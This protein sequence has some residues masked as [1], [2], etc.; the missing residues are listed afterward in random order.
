M[1]HP[2]G[3][4]DPPIDPAELELESGWQRAV[5]MA[6]TYAVSA[7]LH[8]VVAVVVLI[9]L[10]LTRRPIAHE[11]FVA[12]IIVADMSNGDDAPLQERAGDGPKED[13][14]EI[15]E[16]PPPGPQEAMEDPPKAEEPLA[17]PPADPTEVEVPEPDTTASE[18]SDAI[19]KLRPRPAVAGAAARAAT[20]AAPGGVPLE[21]GRAHV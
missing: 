18:L 4:I 3:A 7:L 1:S 9:P 19:A 14:A 2:P 16:A 20:P 15:P 13:P 6:P 8:L 10:V 11:P 12:R 17:A 5:R 21:I